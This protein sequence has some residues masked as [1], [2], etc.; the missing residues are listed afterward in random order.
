MNDISLPLPT[1]SPPTHTHTVAPVINLTIAPLDPN[2]VRLTCSA[3]GYP[4]LDSVAWE[5]P[6][7]ST[8]SGS[9]D[10][11]NGEES[12]MFD[13]SLTSTLDRERS[14]CDGVVYRC[15]VTQG[16]TRKSTSITCQIGTCMYVGDSVIY[17]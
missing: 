5:R 6:D 16:S 13:F 3:R 4:R 17:M 2:Q 7:G 1:P 11:I 14:Q 12:A 9:V 10:V 8:V 15:T